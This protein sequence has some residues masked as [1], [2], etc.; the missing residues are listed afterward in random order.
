MKQL[1][2]VFVVFMLLVLAVPFMV[3]GDEYVIERA[4]NIKR[5]GVL[6]SLLMP[7]FLARLKLNHQSELACTVPGGGENG[8][9]PVINYIVAGYGEPTTDDEYAERL[10]VTYQASGCDINEYDTTGLTPLHDAILFSQPEL[11]RF[12]LA[13]G[14]DPGVPTRTRRAW[15]HGLGAAEFA[16]LIDDKKG[17]P[18]SRT[19]VDI[20]RGG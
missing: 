3:V 1:L 11:V 2:G 12:L 16:L 15:D 14:A 8:N 4:L 13:N 10:I 6:D 20:L 17:T 19:V 7:S 18:E 5:A 9:K